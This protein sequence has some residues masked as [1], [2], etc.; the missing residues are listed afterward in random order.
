MIRLSLAAAALAALT[1]LALAQEPAATEPAATEP[2]ATE[3]ASPEAASS[4]ATAQVINE[5]CP[6][7]AG[8]PVNPEVSVE[9]QG[10]TVY[11]CCAGCPAAFQANP[12]QYLASLPQFAASEA[13]TAPTN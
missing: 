4:E 1:S 5:T 13:E 6:V 12:E 7:M 9:Y 8:R 11:F 10:Q 2:A 3:P